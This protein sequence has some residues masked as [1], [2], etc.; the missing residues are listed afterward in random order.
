MIRLAWYTYSKVRQSVRSSF[1]RSL[2]PRPL[3]F[4][5]AFTIMTQRTLIELCP[6]STPQP[7]R[8]NFL[9]ITCVLIWSCE[10]PQIH[11]TALYKN[12]H[13]DSVVLRL[14]LEEPAHCCIKDF[15]L[16]D[17]FVLIFRAT[18]LASDDPD[19]VR[20]RSSST[21]SVQRPPAPSVHQRSAMYSIAWE[22]QIDQT[23]ICINHVYIASSTGP[24]HVSMHLS[25][26][27]LV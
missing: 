13:N 25:C 3:A 16:D 6:N 9:L 11:N 23:W 22:T 20:F 19:Q 1:K 7:S 2:S 27:L 4:S 24:L 5:S 14:Y 10:W 18:P 8:W 26:P 15:Y 21:I 12:A 17:T